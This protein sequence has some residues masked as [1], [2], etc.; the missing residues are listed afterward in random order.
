MSRS[1]VLFLFTFL[2]LHSCEKDDNLLHP[3]DVGDLKVSVSNEFGQPIEGAKIT[4]GNI[5]NNTDSNGVCYFR[6][7][8]VKEYE[9]TVSKQSFL[10]RIQKIMVVKDESC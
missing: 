1:L 3:A 2:T 6:R 10:P 8:T 4:V 9:I 5:Y 7:L